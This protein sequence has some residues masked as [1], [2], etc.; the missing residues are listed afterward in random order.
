MVNLAS[1]YL[2]ITTLNR[3]KTKNSMETQQHN[4]TPAQLYTKLL[5]Y[6]KPFWVMFALGIFGNL[7]FAASQAAFAE[8][9]RYMTGAI[10]VDPMARWIIPG[11]LV[12]IF[13]VRGLGSFIGDYGFTRVAYGV[14]HN[15]R[16]D[17]FRH[18]IYL[19]NEAIER[20]NSSDLVS[21]ITFDTLQ[22]TESVTNAI[23]TLVREGATVIVLLGYLLWINWLATSVFLIVAPLVLWCLLLMSKRL[24]RLARN[25]Q[26]S[27]GGLTH[28]SA[29]MIH[30]FRVMRIFGGEEYEKARFAKASQH[31]A[32]QN[33][34]RKV[35]SAAAGPLIQLLAVIALAVLV[36]M[37]LSLMKDATAGDILAYITAAAIIPQSMRKLGN[38]LGSI[39]KGVAA[40]DS[41]FGQ[42]DESLED[43]I[44]TGLSP[45]LSGAM[46]FDNI[47]FAYSE[48]ALALNDVSFNVAAG[49][50]VALVGRSGSGKTTLANL[51]P[52][53]IRHQKGR[54]LFDGIP[55][56]EMS[57]KSL[58]SQIA[59]V[60]QNITLFNDTL[61]NNI[62]YGDMQG[63]DEAAIIDAAKKA[64]A[65]EFIQ[66][67]PEGL[68]TL[69]GENGTRL[70]GG[71]RQ[72]IA[73]ARALLKDAPILILD[74]ATSA[75]DNESERH[76]QAGLQAASQG[77]TT[78]II[79]HRLSTIE[80]ADRIIVM[81]K[82]RILEQGKHQELL[83]AQ[84]HYARLYQQGFADEPLSESEENDE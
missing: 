83:S 46:Q 38:V 48:D 10:G 15:L 23:K 25:I 20:H 51:I 70:S 21:R 49:E 5:R 63:A 80:N 82:G 22:V 60:N 39:Q 81:D 68:N 28:A 2:R 42:L 16:Q 33:I 12:G 45:E 47:H 54:L 57:L 3:A 43:N 75:L 17:L 67:L 53:F 72:R 78:I 74:E 30:N 71:Q 26:H 13:V 8:L 52:R 36:F 32:R 24:R 55:I 62:A 11:V 61:A 27:M 1:F 65:W 41:I 34:K 14:V 6:I 18:M 37:A 56:E 66:Q 79:A 40:A 73:I 19:P 7:I 44:E 9:M 50:T 35:T 64:N 29:E 4:L 59:L 58:R 84:G 69:V 77:R 76:I 31:N